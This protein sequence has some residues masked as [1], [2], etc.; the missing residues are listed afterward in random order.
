MPASPGPPARDVQLFRTSRLN[1]GGGSALLPEETP[2]QLLTP[3]KANVEN[4]FF[5]FFLNKNEENVSGADRARI[6]Q[7][8]FLMTNRAAPS[9]AI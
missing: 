4:H 3:T 5:F 6:R 2:V 8:S 1:G 9:K 7:P